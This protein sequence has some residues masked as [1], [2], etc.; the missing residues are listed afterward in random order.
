MAFIR[1]LACFRHIGPGNECSPGASEDYSADSGGN[2]SRRQS[3]HQPLANSL[4]GGIWRRIVDRDDPNVVLSRRTATI[5]IPDKCLAKRVIWIFQ[6]IYHV[7]MV[8]ARIHHE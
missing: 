8:F 3:V 7:K 2:C 6:P 4:T 5:S 1:R